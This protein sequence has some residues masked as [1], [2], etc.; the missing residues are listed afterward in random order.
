[1]KKR[2]FSAVFVL[3]VALGNGFAGTHSAYS[4]F[5]ALPTA[6][7]IE[8]HALQADPEA[9]FFSVRTAIN[10]VDF[11]V[12]PLNPGAS[13]DIFDISGKWIRR[14]PAGLS[15]Q[16]RFAWDLRDGSGREA[17]SGIYV[18]RIR[19]KAFPSARVFALMR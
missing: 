3:G 7:A 12:S 18:A 5:F 15:G 14:L 17:G 11:Q 6:V 19:G 16:G 13:L 8:R 4:G 1:M 2:I 10:R 9:P